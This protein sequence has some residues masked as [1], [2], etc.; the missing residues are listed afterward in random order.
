MLYVPDE[1]AMSR[2]TGSDAWSSEEQKLLPSVNGAKVALSTEGMA[3]LAAFRVK[4]NAVC[5]VALDTAFTTVELRT[6]EDTYIHPSKLPATRIQVRCNVEGSTRALSFGFDAADLDPAT[7]TIAAQTKVAGYRAYH[8]T[9]QVSLL[10]PDVVLDNTTRRVSSSFPKATSGPAFYL[11][12]GV[13]RAQVDPPT[14]TPTSTSTD[15]SPAKRPRPKAAPEQLLFTPSTEA[16]CRWLQK[17]TAVAN[18]TRAGPLKDDVDSSLTKQVTHH[19]RTTYFAGISVV[20]LAVVQQQSFPE[21]LR[22]PRPPPR[23]RARPEKRRRSDGDGGAA[24]P[25]PPPTT[26]TEEE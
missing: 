23:A 25:P 16:Y 7:S 17:A 10:F 12:A 19:E 18:Q 13:Q 22:P 24:A 2:R 8:A 9:I 21:F 20:R 14:P 1:W 11:P 6:N 3:A 4:P 26:T 15:A 5:S